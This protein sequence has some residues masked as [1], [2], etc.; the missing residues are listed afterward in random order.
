MREEVWSAQDVGVARWVAEVALVGGFLSRSGINA[1]RNPTSLAPL[2]DWMAALSQSVQTH[3]GRFVGWKGTVES[4]HRDCF[5]GMHRHLCRSDALQH[6][7]RGFQ[8]VRISSGSAAVMSAPNKA[9]PTPTRNMPEELRTPVPPQART[10]PGVKVAML[11][12]GH[13]PLALLLGLVRGE[14]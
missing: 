14:F 7:R 4:P 2:M 11:C 13:P 12:S 10:N 8:G 5:T 1:S 6:A 3:H 9:G